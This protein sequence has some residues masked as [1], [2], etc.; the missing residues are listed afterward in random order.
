MDV[1]KLELVAI[2]EAVVKVEDAVI[3]LTELSLSL[4]GGGL[5]DISLG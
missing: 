5:G 1:S 4:V 2:Q 3:E